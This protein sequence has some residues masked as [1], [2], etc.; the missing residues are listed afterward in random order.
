MKITIIAVSNSEIVSNE[1]NDTISLISSCLHKNGQ[2]VVSCQMVSSNSNVVSASLASNVEKSDCV[3]LLCENEFE[4]LY[5]CKKLL[6]DL[7]DC[8]MINNT[9]AKFNI[10]EYSRLQN[11][12]LKR[13]RGICSNA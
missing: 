6:C 8:K 2:E 10:D 5:M 11:V 9:F 12:P 4:K 7:F 3:L 1:K 13:G